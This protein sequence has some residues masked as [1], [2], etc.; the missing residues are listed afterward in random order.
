V[1]TSAHL[2]YK[3]LGQQRNNNKISSLG[4]GAMVILFYNSLTRSIGL[5]PGLL[6]L[7]SV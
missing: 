2:E 3:I 7:P 1:K 6:H 4:I 5:T